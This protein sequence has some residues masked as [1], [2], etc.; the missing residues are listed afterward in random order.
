MSLSDRTVHF[1]FPEEEGAYL[2]A[3]E[4][5]SM[6]GRSETLVVWGA[7]CVPD[8]L[9]DD[10]VTIVVSDGK[11]LKDKRAKRVLDFP[12]LKT[13]NGGEDVLKWILKEG[14]RLNIDLT[15]VAGAL[16]VNCGNDLRKIASEIRKLAVIT[17]SGGVASPEL[18]REVMC[19]SA[20]LTPSNVTDAVRDGETA[21]ALAFFDKLQ[22]RGD[23]TGWI[24]AY[25]QR[26]VLQ[27]I[28]AHVLSIVGIAD[29]QAANAVGIPL[30]IY[31]N[32]SMRSRSQDLSSLVL[33]IEHLCRLD[34]M[35]K[36]GSSFARHGLELEIIRLSEEVRRSCR[37]PQS[38]QPTS[39]KRE[40]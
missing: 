23:E 40:N 4:M 30:W 27:S 10:G 21:R 33:G 12:K 6:D 35:H 15:R 3:T 18:A 22:E 16:F 24:I 19:F 7:K 31:R 25:M 17:P 5:R 34:T 8:M 39:R 11:P 14:E 28:H 9:P 38:Q 20:S 1:H 37:T 2:D 13:R 29:E 26:H 36:R 32:V